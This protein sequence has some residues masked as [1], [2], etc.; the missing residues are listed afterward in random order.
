MPNVYVACWTMTETAFTGG[1]Q[2]RA[3]ELLA[4]AL[5]ADTR[6]KIRGNAAGGAFTRMLVVPEYFFNAGNT[7]GLLGRDDKHA[8]YRRLETISAAVPNLLL[9]A[10]TI[11]YGKGVF[12]RKT[13][14]VCPV[15]WGGQIQAKLYK[16]ND[17]GFYQ[18]NGAFRTKTDNGKATPIVTLPGGITLGIDICMD[19][20]DDRLGAYLT[21]QG[22]ARPDIHVQIS[23][24]NTT[25]TPSAQ[26]RVNGVYF[27]CDLGGRGVNGASAWRVT[28][29]NGG[30]AGATTARI[31]PDETLQP[32]IGRV[33]YF[34]TPV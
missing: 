29:Q 2:A 23:G 11:A 20:N 21:A 17:D 30:G 8:I 33:M 31:M 34:T 7:G 9:V 4:M 6:L 15:L 12:S 13:Y 10:G 1:A 18:V 24:S 14:N 3:D 32:G 5:T 16:A 25:G 27:H 28:A 22:V 19:L 26:A